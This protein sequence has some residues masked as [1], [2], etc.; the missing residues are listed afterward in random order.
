M[1]EKSRN[2]LWIRTQKGHK[3]I[4]IQNSIGIEIDIVSWVM[5]IVLGYS[6]NIDGIHAGT[7]KTVKRCREV[8]DEIQSLIEKSY[9][10][11]VIYQM[12]ERRFTGGTK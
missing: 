12:P 2:H 10:E 6:I 11:V 3:L 4:K 5:G 1:N 8:V 9:S 7:Y